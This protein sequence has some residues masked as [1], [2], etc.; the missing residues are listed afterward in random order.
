MVKTSSPGHGAR[1][2]AAGGVERPICH[3]ASA[4]DPVNFGAV[5]RHQILGLEIP[6]KVEPQTMSYPLVI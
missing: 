1:G 4:G 3:P 6:E 2:H 5:E